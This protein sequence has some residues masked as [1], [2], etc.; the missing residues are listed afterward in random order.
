VVF[1]VAA[2]IDNLRS[3]PQTEPAV[4]VVHLVIGAVS[5]GLLGWFL[6]GA[7]ATP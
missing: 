6:R 1:A 3:G 2:V 5:L 4:I 7:T